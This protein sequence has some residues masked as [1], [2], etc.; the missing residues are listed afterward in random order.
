MRKFSLYSSKHTKKCGKK[1]ADDEIITEVD[2]GELARYNGNSK[3]YNLFF[4]LRQ[5]KFRLPECMSPHMPALR[6]SQ[7]LLKNM[8]KEGEAH[9]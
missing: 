2:F 7:P 4:L 8:M 3:V 5:N 9:V 1:G 6:R